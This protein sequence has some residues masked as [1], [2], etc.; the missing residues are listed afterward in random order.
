[1]SMITDNQV[2]ALLDLAW[3]RC[4]ATEDELQDYAIQ[5]RTMTNLQAGDLISTWNKLPVLRS[6]HPVLPPPVT[7]TSAVNARLII[8]KYNTTCSV[9]LNQIFIG[10][11]IWYAKGYIA[12]HKDCGPPT[13]KAGIPITA[14]VTQA[15]AA[16][17]PTPTPPT[18]SCRACYVGFATPDALRRHEQTAHVYAPSLPSK[19]VPPVVL[20]EK[21][22]F[23]VEVPIN[24]VA[25]MRFYR[26]TERMNQWKNAKIR[27]FLRQ[28]GDNWVPIDPME[29]QIA[30][31]IINA[32]PILAKEAYGKLIGSCGNCGKSLTDPESRARGIGPECMK[33]FPGRYN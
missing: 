4:D 33:R 18:Y 13:V 22:Y 15:P 29:R 9:C 32:A 17:V 20:P 3:K 11:Q 6:T 7:P 16:T 26:V 28:S 23:A 10:Q 30:A 24:G 31:A 14:N 5:F 1:M 19:P 21:G 27:T 8:A 2:T 25:I 12:N